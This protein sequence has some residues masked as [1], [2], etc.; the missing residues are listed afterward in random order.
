MIWFLNFTTLYT[1]E[2][3]TVSQNVLLSSNLSQF[4]LALPTSI[5]REV[6]ELV[7]KVWGSRKCLPKVVTLSFWPPGL[8]CDTWES[9]LVYYLKLNTS[10]L[11]EKAKNLK[12][13]LHCSPVT[14][15]PCFINSEVLSFQVS[16][17]VKA[18]GCVE[19]KP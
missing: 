11:Q 12:E 14:L 10:V 19:C 3:A 15:T 16:F 5:W 1:H 7:H 6:M 13:V 8:H 18:V 17:Y 4:I 2:F 9:S